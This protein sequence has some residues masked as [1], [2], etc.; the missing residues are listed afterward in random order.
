MVVIVNGEVV[1]DNDPRAARL[2][3]QRPTSSSS[4]S[5]TATPQRAASSSSSFLQH[6]FLTGEVSRL[7]GIQGRTIRVPPVNFLHKRSFDLPIIYAVLLAAVVFLV[8][9]QALIVL[10]LLYVLFAPSQQQTPGNARQQ[11]R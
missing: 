8:G 6:N 5:G 1:S 4:S 9:F 3:N 10:F 2:R 7:L 11:N